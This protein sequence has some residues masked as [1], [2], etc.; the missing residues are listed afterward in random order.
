MWGLRSMVISWKELSSSTR[1]VRGRDVRRVAQ[2]RVADVAPQVNGAPGG[3]QQ[4]CD[5]GGGRRLA[6]GAG[7]GDLGTG[8]DLKKD[9][10]L[11]GEPAPALH[12]R[13]QLRH[14][15]PQ[16]GGAEDDVL[17]Q[18]FQVV[19]P[20]LEAAAVLLQFAA[21][22]PQGLPGFLVT[23]GDLDAAV[24]QQPDQGLVADT[25]ADDG[26]GLATQGRKIFLKFHGNAPNAAPG[27]RD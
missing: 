15:G 21:Q 5:D 20:Q 27:G 26:H 4:L 13:R 6:V 2:Q 11:A 10:H 8:A 19:L 3:L 23:G 24:Q 12:R 1:Q 18:V 17:R 9:L 7:D 22:G 25:D 16:A 14:V